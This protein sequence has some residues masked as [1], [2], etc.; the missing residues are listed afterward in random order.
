MT[1]K[2]NGSI[3]FNGEIYPTYTSSIT[4]NFMYDIKKNFEKWNDV[5]DQE[6][7]DSLYGKKEK[8][9]DHLKTNW[10]SRDLCHCNCDD[11]RIRD[12]DC[13]IRYWP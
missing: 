10:D 8:I 6:T 2:A 13:R 12:D 3:E 1:D 5:I 4:W 11:S 9:L 7:I